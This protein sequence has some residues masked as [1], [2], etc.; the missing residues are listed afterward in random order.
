MTCDW[1]GQTTTGGDG[2]MI[3]EGVAIAE[4]AGETVTAMN[5]LGRKVISTIQGYQELVVQV[6]KMRQ[7]VVLFKALKDLKK[8]RIESAGS[9]RIE[10]RTDLIITG[11]LLHPQQG[12]DVILAFGLLQ[13][14]LVVQK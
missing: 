5:G 3:I 10:Q 13:G 2:G 1:P 11:N 7:H 9:D 14:A 6:A 8:H 4:L 12:V